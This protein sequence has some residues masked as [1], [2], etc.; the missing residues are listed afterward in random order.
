VIL[1]DEEQP[2]AV[3]YGGAAESKFPEGGR[4]SLRLIDSVITT[5]GVLM[6]TYE[7]DR[8]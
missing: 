7:P 5:K 1:P 6:A 2:R 4:A 3:A 8:D